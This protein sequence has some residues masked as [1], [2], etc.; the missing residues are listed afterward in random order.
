M[1]KKK[2]ILGIFFLLTFMLIINGNLNVKAVTI[3]T[4]SE[5][6]SGNSSFKK[7]T[8][9]GSFKIYPGTNDYGS[10]DKS[11]FGLYKIVDTYYNSSQNTI[12]Y[13]FTTNFQN[14]LNSNECYS[15]FKG[16]TIDPFLTLNI[17]DAIRASYETYS[18]S[19]VVMNGN[20]SSNKFA[21]LMSNYASYIRSNKISYDTTAE[22]TNNTYA[23]NKIV[24]VG[25]YLVLPYS[26]SSNYVGTLSV[27][28]VMVDSVRLEPN[29]SSW[30][31]KNGEIKA[32]ATTSLLN[33]KISPTFSGTFLSNAIVGYDEKTTGKISFSIP[34]YPADS[35]SSIN[36][37][38]ITIEKVR[39]ESGYISFVTPGFTI[40]SF[41]PTGGTIKYNNAIAGNI[42]RNNSTGETIVTFENISELPN[43]IEF[44]YHA[45][46]LNSSNSVIG[47]N[48][49]RATLEFSD[50][51]ISTPQGIFV[52]TESVTLI[53][54]ALQITGTPGAVFQVKDSSGKNKGT[55]SISN[56]GIGELKG[57]ASGTYTVTQLVAPAGYALMTDEKSVTVGTGSNTVPGKEGYY[58]LTW[59]NIVPAI[60]PFTG[61]K[62][63][64]LF[65]VIG[66]LLIIGSIAFIIIYKKKKQ[67][68]KLK[69]N[70]NYNKFDS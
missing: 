17:G 60:L 9:T 4:N 45:E 32:K 46:A 54:Y 7:V 10:Y 48:I 47:N 43:S 66:V 67:K 23:E 5:T 55:V 12:N 33:H 21:K 3:T 25:T 8:N 14:F 13:Q 59:K 41:S 52:R 30:D 35:T 11:N 44:K 61:R 42:K 39:G 62:G 27:F 56:D 64:I 16:L 24:P 15:E 68:E 26:V 50:P 31:L 6:L 20:L 57:L 29:G 53:T 22:N 65:T 37:A 63:T 38:I 58:G 19:K 2:I 51:Y 1:N 18:S 36:T 40:E 49:R 70:K 28:A 34:T 69:T